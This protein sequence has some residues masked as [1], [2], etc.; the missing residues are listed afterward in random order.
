MITYTTSPANALPG[1]GV[2]LI[3]AKDEEAA[4]LEDFS[5]IDY[6]LLIFD[7]LRGWLDGYCAK[8]EK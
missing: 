3:A 4:I 7:V 5:I 6:R 1:N 8:G 2:G